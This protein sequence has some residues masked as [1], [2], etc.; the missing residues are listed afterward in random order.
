MGTHIL[1]AEHELAPATR[2]AS[3]IG[4]PAAIVLA[5]LAAAGFLLGVATPPRSGPFCTIGCVAFPFADADIFF[6]RDYFWMIP[7]VLLTPLFLM[8]AGCLHFCVPPRCK[9]LTLLALCFAAASMAVI[10]LDYSVQVLAVQPSL[11]HHEADGVAFLTQYNPHGAFLALEDLGYLLLA[12]AMLFAGA[13]VPRS[14][15]PGHSLRWL[16]LLAGGLSFAA[17][18]G[19]AAAF[20]SEMALSFEIAII[21]I[22][23]PALVAIGILQALF[24]NRAGTSA[25]A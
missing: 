10:T 9:P 14:I 24:F 2:A 8:V 11:A 18:V 17:F 22:Q 20:G 12:A 1:S 5:I 7:G 16:L 3:R 13:A 15:R 21:L 6:P 25:A 23:W 4:C 19:M